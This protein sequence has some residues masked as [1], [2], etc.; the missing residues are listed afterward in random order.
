[1]HSHIPSGQSTYSCISLECWLQIFYNWIPLEELPWNKEAIT[2]KVML[3]PWGRLMSDDW[4]MCYL[5]SHPFCLNWNNSEASQFQKSSCDSW[6]LCCKG[7]TVEL[8]IPNFTSQSSTRYCLQEHTLIHL[9]TKVRFLESVSRG[10]LSATESNW[11]R[12]LD[13][14]PFSNAYC[15]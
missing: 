15:S 13:T 14:M 2:L 4:S 7:M 12:Q 11:L 10:M 3:P 8:L 1:M 9:H 6:S 5:I